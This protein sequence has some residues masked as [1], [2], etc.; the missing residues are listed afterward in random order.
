MDFYGYS[1]FFNYHNTNQKTMT[2]SSRN[3]YNIKVEGVGIVNTVPDI[4][5]V[6]IGVETLNKDLKLS[7]KENANITNKVINSI[8]NL[9][10]D[11]KDIQTVDYFIDKIYEYVNDERVFM[12]Y[13]VANKIKVIVRDIDKIGN[14][15]DTAVDNGANAVNDIEFDLSDSSPYYDK[16]LSLAVKDALGKAKNIAM[17]LGV[18]INMVPSKVVEQEYNSSYTPRQPSFRAP[19]TV[20]PI[21]PGKYEIKA[22][23]IAEFSYIN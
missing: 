1:P 15:I 14:V 19:E 2:Q 21:E 4:A 9:G 3:N 20:T 6:T 18:R 17:T 16:A 23:V 12:G 11:N 22:I 8:K 5:K 7:Q 13:K 10:I